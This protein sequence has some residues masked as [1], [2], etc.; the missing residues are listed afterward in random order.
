MINRLWHYRWF[1]R[2]W[3]MLFTP[4]FERRAFMAADH[5]P[6]V[7]VAHARVQAAALNLLLPS[8]GEMRVFIAQARR[9]LRAVLD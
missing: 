5:D 1:R 3:R 8:R 6:V 9:T 4:T 2:A 7:A